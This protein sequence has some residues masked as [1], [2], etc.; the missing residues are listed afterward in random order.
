MVKKLFLIKL[1]LLKSFFVPA[2][3]NP[4]VRHSIYKPGILIKIQKI[5]IA[6]TMPVLETNSIYNSLT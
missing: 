3:N 2:K 5:Q 6:G 4:T 1:P